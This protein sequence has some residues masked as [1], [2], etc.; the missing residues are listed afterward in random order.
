MTISKHLRPWAAAGAMLL[1]ATI[2]ACGG[3]GGSDSPGGIDG[4]GGGGIDG[5]GMAFGTITGF[6]SVIVNG[7]E[8]ATTGTTIKL[9]DKLVSQ[10]DLRLGMVVRVDGSIDNR[11]AATITVDDAVKGRVESVI[12]ANRIVVMGQTVLIDNLTQIGNGNAARGDYVEVH[13]LPSADGVVTAGFIERKTTLPTPPFAVKGF[14]K[15][16]DTAA[17]SFVVG[18]LTVNYG[19]ALSSDMP[20]GSWNGLLVDAKG[21]ACA[22]E[23]VCGTLAATKVEPGGAAVGNIAKAE[24]EG[25]VV[26]VNG[27]AFTIGAQRI[28]VGAGTQFEGGVLG[29]VV[30]GA[31]L[32]AEGPIA[33]G[34]LNAVKVSFKDSL[35][36]EADVAAVS[37]NTLTLAGLPGITVQTNSLT[38][39]KDV[40]SIAGL[41]APNHL[42]IKARQGAGGSILALEVERRSTASDTRTI[43]QGPV[44]TAT[45]TRLTVLGVAIDTS[46]ISQFSNLADAAIDRAAFLDAATPGRLVKA[47]GERAGSGVAWS[48]IELED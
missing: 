24:V 6:G 20:A 25:F 21:S 13:G 46:T 7:I 29:D 36:L 32:E 1:A 33:N 9:D 48:E 47:R 4:T 43:L 42:R 8:F 34:V 27:N 41:A 26:S 10:N 3:G 35:R 45:G 28:V 11:Q 15:S 37:G 44:G 39:F 16:H 17:R 12:D 18:T 5:T 38:Q 2:G 14:V 30:A 23:P 40:A 19:G 31:K 22:G